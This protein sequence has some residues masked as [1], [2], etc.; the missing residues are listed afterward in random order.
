MR[1]TILLI[2]IGIISFLGCSKKDSK[3]EESPCGNHITMSNIWDTINHKPWNDPTWNVYIEGNNRVFQ[4]SSRIYDSVCPHK[5]IHLSGGT[6]LKYKPDGRYFSVR[7][8]YRY[9]IMFGATL[10]NNRSYSQGSTEYSYSGNTD[11]GIAQCYDDIPGA[12][13]LLQEWVLENYLNDDVDLEYFR[14]NYV[15]TALNADFDYWKYGTE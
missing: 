8:K 11:F 10:E 2:T 7:V 9:G 4:V 13:Y 3:T 5:H 15:R 6:A 14:N 12:F 1:T